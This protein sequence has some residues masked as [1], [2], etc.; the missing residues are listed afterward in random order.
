MGIMEVLDGSFCLYANDEKLA[1]HKP[2][3]VTVATNLLCLP[4][5]PLL[6]MYAKSLLASLH[7]SKQAYH[8]YKVGFH[9]SKSGY[10]LSNMTSNLKDHAML[11][12]VLNGLIAMTEMDP[13]EYINIDTESYYRLVMIARGIAVARPQNLVKFADSQ[14][15]IQDVVL[16]DP[17]GTRYS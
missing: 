2:L 8:N 17:L 6:Q 12:H 16:D 5:P 11:K 9:T 13:K 7:S 14:A 3:S 10:K 4:L 15:S 1:V